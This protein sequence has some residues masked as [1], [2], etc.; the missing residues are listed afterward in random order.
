MPC[1]SRCSR[2]GSVDSGIQPT[3]P[4]FSRNRFCSDKTLS[5]RRARWLTIPRRRQR[6]LQRLQPIVE[7]GPPGLVRVDDAEELRLLGHQRLFALPLLRNLAL[8]TDHLLLYCSL[9]GGANG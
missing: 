5:G 9:F 6:S 8:L 3:S 1:S 2:A 7:L 4:R